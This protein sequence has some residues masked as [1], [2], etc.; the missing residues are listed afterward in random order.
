MVD[1]VSVAKLQSIDNMAGELAR[2]GQ[3]ES[4]L[5]LADSL[6]DADRD[7]L[8]EGIVYTLAQVGNI[9]AAKD[10]GWQG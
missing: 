3:I 1:I 8:L 2:A 10:C 7:L 4:A 9:M 5:G 6:D